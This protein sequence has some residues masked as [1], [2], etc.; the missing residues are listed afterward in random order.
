MRIARVHGISDADFQPFRRCNVA[1]F[2][3]LRV[4]LLSPFAKLTPVRALCSRIT[5]VSLDALINT[6]KV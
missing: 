2:R 6:L 3:T 1:A 5:I 4:T